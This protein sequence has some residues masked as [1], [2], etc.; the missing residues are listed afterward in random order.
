M[1]I[2]KIIRII[3]FIENVEIYSYYFYKNFSCNFSNKWELRIL[4][5]IK[6]SNMITIKF[7]I[8][9]AFADPIKS[10]VVP[11][12]TSRIPDRRKRM[13][14][15]HTETTAV[16]Q[17]DSLIKPVT[18][19]SN[20]VIHQQGCGLEVRLLGRQIKLTRVFSYR[21]TACEK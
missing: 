20:L 9:L 11:E 6:N 8:C 21:K 19:L 17:V 15:L 2:F 5:F 13:K 1:L 3:S 14:V 4:F 12:D 16:R 10:T 18:A 7:G